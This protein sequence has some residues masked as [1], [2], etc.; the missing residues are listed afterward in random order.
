MNL[1][2]LLTVLRSPAQQSRRRRCNHSGHAGVEAL[3]SRQLL[4]ADAT[5][6]KNIFPGNGS[7]LPSPE[8]QQTPSQP[9]NGWVYFNA[10]DGTHG[11]E[12]WRTDGTEVNTHRFLDLT[13]GSGRS[14]PH[15]FIVA[16]G[17]L[18]FNAAGGN[19]YVTDGTTVGT[20]LLM[21]SGKGAYAMGA[22]G[23]TVYFY[24]S[25]PAQ[26]NTESPGGTFW[27]TDGTLAGTVAIDTWDLPFPP[28]FSTVFE[29]TVFFTGQFGQLFKIDPATNTLVAVSGSPG[30]ISGLTA[31]ANDRV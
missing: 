30:G 14:D 18:F 29:N 22:V 19:L 4:A 25:D 2:N 16:N 3:E 6:L 8:Q 26:G 17:K 9:L 7:S 11:F 1:R 13:P 27:K 31:T 5:V 28:G 20:T 12:L 24:Y 21:A 23:S 15:N 10:N